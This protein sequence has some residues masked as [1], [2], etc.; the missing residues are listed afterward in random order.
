[1]GNICPR[2]CAQHQRREIEC[3]D[4]CHYLRQGGGKDAFQAAISRLL[5]F[6]AR[7]EV[8]ARPAFAK[9]GGPEKTLGEWEEPLV[10]AYV[11][12]GYA[13][14]N[15][16][17]AIDVFLRGHGDEL[18]VAEREA[19]DAVQQTAWPSLFEVQE[20]QVD[21]GLQLTDLVAGDEVFIRKKT[22]THHQK[23]F[24][25]ILGWLVYL[26]DHFEM[27]GAAV[28][29]P[30]VHREAVL[31][32]IKKEMRRLREKTDGVPDRILL[33]DAIVAGQQALRHA[34]E[35]WRPPKMVTMDG[36]E[37]VFCEALFDV[38]DM[39][40]VRA[41]LAEHPDMDEDEQGFTWVDRKGREQL[42][43]GSLSLGTIRFEKGRMKLETKSRERIERGKALLS[44]YLAGIARHRIDSIKDLDVAME[45]LADRPPRDPSDEIPEEIQA[46]VLGPV[47]QQ[48]I[49]SWV[50]QSIPALKGKTPRRAVK[51]K[52]GRAKVISMLKDQE[53]SMLRQP[54]GDLVDF[55]I[56]YEE[57]GLPR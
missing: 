18:K 12:H 43:D 24:D 28:V 21:V 34:F 17:R 42:G 11:A 46:Q 52:A 16:D 51:T 26:G 44:E 50:D 55:G 2:C 27:T 53:N 31:K 48:H 35:N 30:R 13:D 38:T 47:L 3:P 20:V 54:G 37:I 29:V 36:E 15:G 9:L 23:K 25:L 40:A 49:E 56:V 10:W 39:A 6:A 19:L 33:R 41:K 8:R 14:A 45:E 57:L 1:M 7:D 4:D 22:G 32:A 5:G